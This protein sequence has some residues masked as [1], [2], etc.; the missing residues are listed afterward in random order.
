MA[1]GC[2]HRQPRNFR[3][4][5][6]LI[7]VPSHTGS[8]T[9]DPQIFVGLD[10][11]T[12]NDY[13]YVR[14][15]VTPCDG[16]VGT[17]VLAPTCANDPSGWEAYVEAFRNGS[18]VFHDFIPLSDA[19]E[20]DKVFASVYREPSGK[21]VDAKI[22]LPVGTTFTFAVGMA[23]TTFGRAQAL[24]DWT[25]ARVNGTT[26]VP[27]PASPVDFRD[28]QFNQGGFTTASGQRGTF[29]GPWMLNAIDATTN[30]TVLG[31]IVEEPAFLWDDGQGN[32]FGDAFGVWNRVS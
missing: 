11:S 20:G 13:T 9:L 31:T 14:A 28:T 7:T 8:S 1:A 21:V 18:D 24:A 4:T 16:S 2:L 5:Q 30:G 29:K 26:V 32:G 12:S 15:G 22:V 17:I 27:T 23:G 25:N 19:V 10:N 3:Y 6:A